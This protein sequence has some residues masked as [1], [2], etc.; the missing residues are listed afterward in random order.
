MRRER[1][2]WTFERGGCGA[3]PEGSLLRHRVRH[4]ACRVAR[5]EIIAFAHPGA[6]GLVTDD[7][8]ADERIAAV[9]VRQRMKGLAHASRPAIGPQSLEVLALRRHDLDVGPFAR[10]Q[11]LSDPTGRQLALGSVLE[12]G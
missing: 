4:E 1:S 3:P 5:D 12:E 10:K 11:R 8:A 7:P 9:E 6:G 2:F